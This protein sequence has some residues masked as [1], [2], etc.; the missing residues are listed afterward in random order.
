MSSTSDN[1]ALIPP[2]VWKILRHA[3]YIEKIYISI[4]YSPIF[5]FPFSSIFF[6]RAR[7]SIS[8]F[9]AKSLLPLMRGMVTRNPHAFILKSRK[10]TD[11]RNDRSPIIISIPRALRESSPHY[12]TYLAQLYRLA[13]PIRYRFSIYSPPFIQP[14]FR[15]STIRTVACALQRSFSIE[16]FSRDILSTESTIN[17]VSFSTLLVRVCPF[18]R[19]SA[20]LETSWLAPRLANHHL[21]YISAQ[22]Q[23]G[24]APRLVVSPPAQR[25]KLGQPNVS[26]GH[27]LFMLGR[28]I[29]PPRSEG[30][31]IR[32][33]TE[34]T[35][36]L[37]ELPFC[38]V[39]LSIF[40]TTRDQKREN[41]EHSLL[42]SR[43]ISRCDSYNTE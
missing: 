27:P 17:P 6:I 36:A 20:N 30:K 32:S 31:Q 37:N 10:R 22:V 1:L 4:E 2:F 15:S 5:I 41:F 25:W 34:K 19:P 11:F 38:T 9:T 18:D 29:S 43:R 28:R 16:R 3:R 21:L 33:F 40:I 42:S 7:E 26:D 8:P 35:N 23:G 14:F 13:G 39:S 24:R 12:R